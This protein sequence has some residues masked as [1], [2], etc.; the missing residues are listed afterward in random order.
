MAARR[1]ASAV[2]CYWGTKKWQDEI[3]ER[4][5]RRRAQARPIRTLDDAASRSAVAALQLESW[6][7]TYGAQASAE[8]LADLPQLLD[9]RWRTLVLG[10]REFVLLA[11]NETVLA[12]ADMA[13]LLSLGAWL[14]PVP[15]RG[16]YSG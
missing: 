10:R 16:A 2:R 4:Q 13:A 5:L 15:S 3:I 14:H 1:A 7:D 6:R 8:Y 9:A 12:D 11:G